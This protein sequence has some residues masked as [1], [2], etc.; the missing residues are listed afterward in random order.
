M[1]GK[2]LYAEIASKAF[3]QPY[4]ECLEHFPQGSFIIQHTNGSWYYATEEEVANKEFNV[5]LADGETDVYKVGKER[6]TQAKS[7]LLGALYGRGVASIAEQLGCTEQEAQAIKDS[8]FMAFPA[9]GEFEKT[10]LE[11]GKELGY[12][13]T[14]CGRKRRLPDLQLPEY[15]FSWE[16]GFAPEGDILDFDELEVE[17][18]HNK[19]VYYTNRL[20]NARGWKS[21]D[22]VIEIAKKEHIEIVSNRGKIGDATRQTVNS[23]IQGSSADLTK[24]AMIKLYLNEKLTKLGF[25]LLIQVHDEVIAECP[26]KNAKKCAKLLAKIMCE[27]AEEILEMPIKCDVEC[28]DRWYGKEYE[29]VYDEDEEDDD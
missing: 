27:S 16:E 8:V 29:F 2:D 13:T 24:I 11:M 5:R 1:E 10:S 9:I 7:I 6:R 25:R 19:Q 28:S 14:V 26:K 17:V 22:K 4:E 15:S 20:N 18:P 12:V 23:R 21:R 3:N